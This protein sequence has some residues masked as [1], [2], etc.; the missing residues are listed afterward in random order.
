MSAHVMDLENIYKKRA[1]FM[2][3]RGYL[4][5][6]RP[7][8]RVIREELMEMLDHCRARSGRAD[9]RIHIRVLKDLDKS[10]G[11]LSCFAM[12]AGIERRLAATR[13]ALVK[14]NL[15]TRTSQDFDRARANVRTKLIDKTGDKKRNLHGV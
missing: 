8:R 6:T 9:D 2:C 5:G 11:K 12:V 4:I 1:E 7:Q 13:L 14:N 10:S 3:F 15:A